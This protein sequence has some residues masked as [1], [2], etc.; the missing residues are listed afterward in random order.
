MV[1][2]ENVRSGTGKE[3]ETGLWEEA[4]QRLVCEHVAHLTNDKKVSIVV[5]IE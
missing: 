5:D 3:S 4:T 1:F 2:L